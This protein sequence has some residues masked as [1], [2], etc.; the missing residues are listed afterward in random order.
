MSKALHILMTADAVGGVWTYALELARALEPHDVTITL[1]TMGAM[2]S[3]EQ[4][5][6][7]AELSHVDLRESRY[8]L[9]WMDEPWSDVNAA[10]A[11]LLDLSASV[12]PD[13]LHFNG[14]AHAALP[15][16]APGL[17]VVHSC[18]LSWWCAV[19]GEAAPRTYTEYRRR[20]EMGL[21]AAKMIVAP[22]HAMLEALREHYA[23]CGDARVI[24][25]GRAADLFHSAKK[26]PVIVTAGR[27]WDEAKNIALLKRIAPQ[28]QWPVHVAGQVSQ[29]ATPH[30]CSPAGING[31]GTVVLLG[32]LSP[33]D[34]AR[35]LGAASIYAAPA[36]YEPFGLSILEAALC[37]C[38]LVLAD[39]PSLR[40]HWEG[41]ALFLPPDDDV[42]WVRTLNALAGDESRRTALAAAA[43]ERSGHFAP[44]AMAAQYHDAY[45]ELIAA[46]PA[47]L[48][49]VALS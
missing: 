6:E 14:Y 8:A 28:L 5:R 37:G 46:Q 27:V 29:P 34:L 41:A 40:E 10:G 49:E 43:I 2:P 32:Q 39:L 33:A 48:E 9:E 26:E 30:A 19:K 31:N 25:N 21:R 15:W 1:A 44:A 38:A 16:N 11:W 45:R 23:F 13:V 24:P 4:R 12:R 17:V 22:S 20:V 7:A 47:A 36:R 42:A 3:R 35:H 18:V